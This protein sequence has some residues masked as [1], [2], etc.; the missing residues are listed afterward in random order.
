MKVETFVPPASIEN[1]LLRVAAQKL[2]GDDGLA[3]I[4]DTNWRHGA[5]SAR[6]YA[7]HPDDPLSA[8][9]ENSWRKEFGRDG[10]E[11]AIEG[12]SR[13]TVTATELHLTARLDAWE[14]GEKVF[15]HDFSHV[16]PR[17]HL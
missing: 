7:I 13:M 6:R 14:N 8:R 1:S 11:V 12:W 9:T 5:R 16:I 4:D 2:F 10:F 3:L 15:G 17:D